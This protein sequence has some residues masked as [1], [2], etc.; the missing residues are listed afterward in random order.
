MST[1][2]PSGDSGATALPPRS[3]SALGCERADEPKKEGMGEFSMVTK[4]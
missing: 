4:R 3:D 1:A 2:P